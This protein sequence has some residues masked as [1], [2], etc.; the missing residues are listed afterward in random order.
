MEMARAIMGG[1]E[2]G[3]S[4]SVRLMTMVLKHGNAVVMVPI[5]RAVRMRVVVMTDALAAAAV[6]R[7][8]QHPP[9][10]HA[11]A[12]LREQEKRQE[13]ADDQDLHEAG[14]ARPRGYRPE[15]ARCQASTI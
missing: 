6:D 7:D 12:H 4:R 1:G 13:D 10:R 11:G 9:R 14:L 2:H 15:M 8:A 5:M 3:A